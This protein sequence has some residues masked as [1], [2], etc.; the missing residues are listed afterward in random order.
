VSV[1][2][3][4]DGTIRMAN[5]FSVN[6]QCQKRECKKIRIIS[7]DESDEDNALFIEPMFFGVLGHGIERHGVE[8]HDIKNIASKKKVILNF[9]VILSS[10]F[11]SK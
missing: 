4:R 10:M 3:R 2:T 1:W 8:R 6:E 5:F 9:H 7:D 11:H